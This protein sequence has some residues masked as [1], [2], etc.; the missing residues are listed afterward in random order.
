MKTYPVGLPSIG[1]EEER[2]VLEALR[3]GYLSLGPKLAEFEKRFAETIGTKYAC[4]VNSGTSGLHLSMIAAG[5][6][7]G[8]EVITTPFSFIASANCVL[9]VGATPVFVDIDPKTSNMDVTKIEAAITDKTKA[10]LVVHIFG[11]TCDMDPIMDIAKRRNLIVIED[12][13]ESVLASYKGRKAGTFGQSAVFAFYP[14]KQM[15]TGEGGIV[16]TDDERVYKLC[17]SLA[18]QG[19]AENMQWLDHQ[20]L[21]YNYR[22]DEMSAAL[23]VEQL[24]KLPSFIVAR[25]EIAAWYDEAFAT[26]GSEIVTPFVPPENDHTYFVYVVQLPERAH[27]DKM[28]GLLKEPGVM[29]KPYLPSIHLFSFYRE[30]FGFKDGDF[31]VSESVS[32]RSLALPI[33]VGLTQADVREI[34]ARVM[35]TLPQSYV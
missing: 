14:N 3:S 15:T 35:K 24:K 17:K 8:D 31:P 11:Q 33:Y 1:P 12:A 29:S 28:I 27:R 22:M 19:R 5:I 13:C 25:K 7:P 6:G 10:I 34:V 20:Y 26:S 9:Y 32:R 23:G 18:N 2:A 21:G 16:V 30:R 4:A